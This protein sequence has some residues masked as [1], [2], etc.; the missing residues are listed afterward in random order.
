MSEDI[1]AMEERQMNRHHQADYGSW[2]GREAW[3]W[4]IEIERKP[5]AFLQGSYT[6]KLMLTANKEPLTSF[7]ST[8]LADLHLNANLTTLSQ[9]PINKL[10]I[11]KV[12]SPETAYVVYKAKR[13]WTKTGLFFVLILGLRIF[14]YELMSYHIHWQN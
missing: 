13:S 6:D 12:T 14:L 3:H 1:H 5:T 8:T 4:S 11:P 2:L 7:N 9:N 10:E